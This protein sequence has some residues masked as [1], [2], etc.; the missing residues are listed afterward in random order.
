DWHVFFHCND[1]IQSRQAA[2]LRS[3]NYYSPTAS[4]NRIKQGME[5]DEGGGTMPRTEVTTSMGGMAC[6]STLSA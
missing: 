2:W 4:S 1:N 6:G 5:C 3:C